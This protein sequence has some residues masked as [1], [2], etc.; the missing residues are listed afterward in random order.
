[1][2]VKSWIKCL[3]QQAQWSY[4]SKAGSSFNFITPRSATGGAGSSTSNSSISSSLELSNSL[5]GGAAGRPVEDDGGGGGGAG[6]PSPKSDAGPPTE[7]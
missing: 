7:D 5:A 2:T 4:F 6:G 1:M 3:P